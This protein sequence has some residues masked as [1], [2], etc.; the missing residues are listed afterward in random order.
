MKSKQTEQS[1]FTNDT[2]LIDDTLPNHL[3][4]IVHEGTDEE[5][6]V[7]KLAVQ[8]IYQ[9]RERQSAY[10]SGF[11]GLKG[12]FVDQETYQFKVPITAFM[13]NR[14]HMVHG[15]ITA[16]LADSTMG[17]LINQRLPDGQ[18]CVTSE[19]KVNYISPGR[20]TTLISQAKIVHM[21][22]QLCVAECRITN[23]KGKLIVMATG[24]FFVINYPK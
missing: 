2:P 16:T 4:K 12:E 20:G 19:M 11:M 18:G 3:N 22:K 8:A 10:L 9:K 6:E 7:L 23:E 1:P 17:S 15:G 5:K 13:M 21:G 24:T 14:V